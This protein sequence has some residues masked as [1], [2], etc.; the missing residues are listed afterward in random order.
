[1]A[2]TIPYLDTFTSG[3]VDRVSQALTSETPDR[4]EAW[5]ARYL[6]LAVTGIRSDAVARKISLHLGRFLAFFKEAYGHDRISA[7]LQRDVL[8]WQRALRDQP[9]APATVNN[10]LASLS[11]F[12]TWVAAQDANLFASGDPAKGVSEIPLPPLEPKALNEMQVRSLKNLCDRLERFH[13]LKGRRWSKQEGPPP[14]KKRARPKR[15]RAILFVLL[16]TGLRRE[17]LVMLDIH[18]VEPKSP[19]SLRTARRARIVKV[20]GKGGTERTVFLSADARTA[21]ADYM[22]IERVQDADDNTTPLF[23][24]P[25]GLAARADDGRLSTRAVNHILEQIGRWHDAETPDPARHISPLRPHDLRHTFAFQLAKA[26]GAD[27]YELERRLGHRSQRYIQR[28]TNPPE[29]IAAEY[30]EDF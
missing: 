4:L 24:T 9:L 14:L 10:H 12:T 22:E 27:A 26:T 28:Y 19:E 20:K 13:R 3:K 6:T 7:C 11:A 21:L 5:I 1:M 15:D 17:E 18:Q 25:A 23:L 16:S 30:V 8:A 29:H 2:E